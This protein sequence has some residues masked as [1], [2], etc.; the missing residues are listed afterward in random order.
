MEW[1]LT[2]ILFFRNMKL[3]LGQLR[4][5]SFIPFLSS[6]F[7]VCILSIH[8]HLMLRRAAKSMKSEAFNEN[9]QCKKRENDIILTFSSENRHCPLAHKAKTFSILL[10]SPIPSIYLTRIRIFY[11]GE[12][13]HWKIWLFLRELKVQ[14][15]PVFLFR[16]TWV[17]I[18]TTATGART[19]PMMLLNLFKFFQ[20]CL[21]ASSSYR[22]KK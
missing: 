8:C 17:T 14:W 10:F 9:F 19:I 20:D 7:P 21:C 13:N 18:G 22:S 11:F 5:N 6:L 3:L 16:P 4:L 1:K 2:D 15:L 12:Q